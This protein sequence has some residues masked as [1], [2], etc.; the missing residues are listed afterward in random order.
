[1]PR[2]I[3]TITTPAKLLSSIELLEQHLSDLRATIVD[4]E[5]S[6]LGE[7]PVYYF[8]SYVKSVDNICRFAS[9]VRS[10]LL[11]AKIEKARAGAKQS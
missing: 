4:L 10:Q 5:D 2:K 3:E 6:N 1:M 11:N 9:S 8:E 7:L